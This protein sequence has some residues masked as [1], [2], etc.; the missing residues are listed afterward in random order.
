MDRYETIQG[1]PVTEKAVT[2]QRHIESTIMMEPYKKI[3]YYDS[4]PVGYQELIA[5]GQYREKI[6]YFLFS[7]TL[8]GVKKRGKQRVLQESEIGSTTS[9]DGTI[10]FNRWKDKEWI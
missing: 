8:N 1:K 3:G 2:S 7:K 4:F 10:H 9:I 5:P 6:K